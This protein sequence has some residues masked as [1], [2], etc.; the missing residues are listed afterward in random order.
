MHDDKGH[1]G[2]EKPGMYYL[3]LEKELD[4]KLNSEKLVST[5]ITRIDENNTDD[6]YK[7]FSLSK[8]DE[9]LLLRSEIEITFNIFINK[10]E[11]PRY[12]SFLKKNVR[13]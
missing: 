11:K 6:L 7:K 4:V 8:D 9:N 10:K 12:F 13:S 5:K 2:F 1:L 3:N